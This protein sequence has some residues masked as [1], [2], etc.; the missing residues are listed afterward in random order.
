MTNARFDPAVLDNDPARRATMLEIL[1][2]ALNEVEPDR[3]VRRAFRH[4][5][6][7]LEVAGVG[8]DTTAIDRVHLL[9]FGKAA[10]AMARAAVDELRGLN[11][12]GLVISNHAEPL[13]VGLDLQIT[14]HPLPDERSA[15]AARTS[16]D[17]LQR[18][19]EQDL[20]LCLISGG[21]SALLELPAA[22]ISM[23]DEQATVDLLLSCGADIEE[24]NTVR[25]HLSAI[26]GGRLAEAAA[27]ARLCT[28]ILSDVVG[29][30][31]DV[32][33][34]G[35][36][37]PDPT[38]YADALEVLDRYGLHH[39]VPA[40]IVAHLVAGSSESIDETP[41]TPYARQLLTIVGD[42]RAAAEGAAEV[43]RRAGLPATIATTTMTGDARTRAFE[44]LQEVKEQGVTIFAG[45]TTVK[46]VGTGRGG[47]NQ[48]AALAAAHV[49]AGDSSIVFATFG[50]DG[51]DGP[52]EAAGA[53]VDGDTI[54]RGSA[55][56]LDA[57]RYLA[58][59]DS[60]PYLA[61]TGDLLVTGPTGTNVGDL[62]I[63]WRA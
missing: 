51:V 44:C 27:P 25:K 23:A 38:T 16:L 35:P 13:P 57:E 18:A 21:G 50:T 41:K 54:A 58:N 2:G 24:L 31:L 34:S 17:L 32:I 20:V 40:P 60:G 52:T 7:G 53:I 14:G 8:L 3:A 36:S 46:V 19:G 10:P 47:R 42:G 6:T 56:G 39:R 55:Q 30:R 1:E 28:L 9:A 37:V 12:G 22:G 15:E 59:N 29:N 48:E 63:V 62:W 11:I 61:A 26:K 45:E 49:L 5:E 4:T 33:A 43:A